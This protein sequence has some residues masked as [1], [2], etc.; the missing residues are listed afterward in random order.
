MSLTH[1]SLKVDMTV[2][3]SKAVSNTRHTEVLGFENGSSNANNLYGDMTSS[4]ATIAFGYAMAVSNGESSILME[5]V[6]C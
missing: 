5:R 2:V 1:D 3:I 6:V 4:N